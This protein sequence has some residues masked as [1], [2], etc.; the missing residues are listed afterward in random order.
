MFC[1][2]VRPCNLGVDLDFCLEAN[3]ELADLYWFLPFFDAVIELVDGDMVSWVLIFKFTGLEEN[4]WIFLTFVMAWG[5]FL[6]NFVVAFPLG[7]QI[8]EADGVALIPGSKIG[9][10]SSLYIEDWRVK[11]WMSSGLSSCLLWVL[12]CQFPYSLLVKVDLL[13]K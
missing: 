1:E 7:V 10:Y 4:Y 8:D 12:I 3:D 11:F 9:V 5:Y 2:T 13:L 6:D